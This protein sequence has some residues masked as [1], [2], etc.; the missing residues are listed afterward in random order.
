MEFYRFFHG[1]KEGSRKSRSRFLW[2]LLE[3]TI[4]RLIIF[5]KVST[6]FLSF[7]LTN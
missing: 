3:E 7:F 4:T 5:A 1:R 6:I 2:V